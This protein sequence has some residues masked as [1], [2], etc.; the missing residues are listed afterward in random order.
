MAYILFFTEVHQPKR[1]RQETL[2]ECGRFDDLDH[3]CASCYRLH[4]LKLTVYDI[5]ARLMF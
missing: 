5:T 3:R 1:L 2:R 4:V